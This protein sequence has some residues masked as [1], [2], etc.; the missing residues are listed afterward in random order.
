[1]TLQRNGQGTQRMIY[2]VFNISYLHEVRLF[3]HLLTFFIICFSLKFLFKVYVSRF[4]VRISLQS[5]PQPG[6]PDN[7]KVN[8][9]VQFHNISSNVEGTGLWKV[10]MY[11]SVNDEGDIGEGSQYVEQIL[12]EPQQSEAY[13]GTD[14]V[15]E[16]F[17]QT[18]DIYPAFSCQTEY[19]YLCLKFI[20]GDNPSVNF[21]LHPSSGVVACMYI[22]R[23][24]EE[25]PPGKS[26]NDMFM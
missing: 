25:P 17:D 3:S 1:M 21:E 9:T 24:Q 2:L 23:E 10:S 7:M 15:F 8:L 16:Q 11:D 19:Q 26:I 20:K 13:L 12:P 5:M 18:F 4:D 14:V 6:Q 22:C